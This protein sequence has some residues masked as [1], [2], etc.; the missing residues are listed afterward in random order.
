MTCI[1]VYPLIT[2]RKLGEVRDFYRIRFGLTV[3]FEASWVVMLGLPGTEA[4]A[5][6]LMSPD[7]PTSPPGPEVFDGRGVVVTIQ[8]ADAARVCAAMKQ[9]GDAIVHD[10]RDE[11]WGQRR[12]MTRDPGGTLVDVVEQIAPAPGYWDQYRAAARRGR[13]PA[14]AGR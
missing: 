1:D 2:T 5:L 3:V 14:D 4:I 9:A 7:H 11:P 6:G 13:G 8:V 10:I 12:F